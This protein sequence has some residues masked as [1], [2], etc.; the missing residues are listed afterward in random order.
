MAFWNRS[1]LF[2][3]LALPVALPLHAQQPCERLSSLD[4]PGVTITLA[5]T[6]PAGSFTPTAA[7]AAVNVPAFCRVA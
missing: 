2:A 7:R 5:Q 3:T 1:F 6:V 4:L